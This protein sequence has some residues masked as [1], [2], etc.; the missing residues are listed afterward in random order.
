[1]SFSSP[2][3]V[4][5][6][7][8]QFVNMEQ[9]VMPPSMRS[10]RMEIIAKASGNPEKCA[11]AIHI[12][13]SKGKGSITA[14]CAAMIEAAGY[15]VARYMSP[16][17]I[18]YRERITNGNKYFDDKIYIAAGEKLCLIQE[19]LANPLS[20]EYKALKDVSD[21]GSPEPTFFELL[22]LYFFLCAKEAKCNF[23]VVETGMGGRLDPTNIS[24]SV[25]TVITV[26]ELEHTDML[27]DTIAKIAFEKAGIIKAKC[28][29]VLAEQTHKDG[30]DA[31]ALIKKIADEKAAPVYYFPEVANITDLSVGKEGTQC[32]LHLKDSSIEIKT[33]IPGRIQAV[34]ASLAVLAVKHALNSTPNV[35]AIETLFLPARFERVSS[36]P[37]I[38]I[39]GAH[40]DLSVSLCAETFKNIYGSGG[41]LIF[42]CAMG[43]DARAMARSLIPYFSKIIIT[44]P[45]TFK[46]SEPE[47]VFDIFTSEQND[48]VD[49]QFIKDTKQAIQCVIETGNKNKLPVLGA[50]SFY[51]AAEIRNFIFGHC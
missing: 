30:K 32:T 5:D 20:Q 27:G 35:K 13:G 45:G 6:W 48:S 24:Q 1:M 18:D 41:V 15:K 25:C 34:N 47:K 51:L 36:E 50:G 14:M 3:Q 46:V 21:G 33:P 9:G 43:K 8:G 7:L 42:G 28:P 23:L 17:I 31:L 37:L 2:A 4:F 26:I 38:I 44:T 11:P 22:T 12:A 49:I 29:L 19:V 10:E 40:T 39:D 16:H